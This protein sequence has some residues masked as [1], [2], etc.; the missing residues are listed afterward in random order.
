MGV[1]SL[2]YRKRKTVI[3]SARAPILTELRQN[4]HR[5]NC[6]YCN[7]PLIRISDQLCSKQMEWN[8]LSH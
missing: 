3:P 1:F 5:K 6:I 8:G 7:S 4:R 2:V